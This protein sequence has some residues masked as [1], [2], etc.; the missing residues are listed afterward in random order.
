MLLKRLVTCMYLWTALNKA[1]LVSKF[2]FSLPKS[3]GLV[4]RGRNI[5]TVSLKTCLSVPYN[6]TIAPKPNAH[7]FTSTL[8]NDIVSF[9]F[10]G[11]RGDIRTEFQ[12]PV[13]W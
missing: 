3:I 12:A 10:L 1:M 5:L 7:N 9:W 2:Q 8:R 13:I 11:Y 4:L 6:T